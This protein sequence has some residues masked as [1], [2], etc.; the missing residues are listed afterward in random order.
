VIK[1]P[2]FPP[3]ELSAMKPRIIARIQSVDADWNSA[4]M[5]FFKHAYFGPRNSPYQ[6]IIP[7]T[8]Q[9]VSSFTAK[10]CA[11]WYHDKVLPARKVL[12]IYGDVS[13]D[14]ARQLA[15]KEFSGN[16]IASHAPAATKP[17]EAIPSLTKVAAPT[18]NVERI[19]VNKTELPVAGVIIGYDSD[20]VL[21]DPAN[22]P[23]TVGQTMAG[24]YG[25]PTGYLFEI[26]R[27]RGL[28]Y[29]VA[30]QNVPGR[31]AHLPGTFIVYAGC[32]PDKVNEVVNTALENI[33][34]LQGSAQAMQP[35]WFKRSK[36]LITTADALSREAPADQAMTAALDELFG[37]GYDYHDKFE[38]RINAVTLDQVRGIARHRLVHCVVTVSTPQPQLVNI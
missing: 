11:D 9:N 16:E 2:S 23:L 20:S 35:G 18:V 38:Q 8:K 24:G 30:D 14:A 31:N 36:E 21:G 1:N 17:S 10:D 12:A 5:K 19:A 15:E 4:S 34:R 22:F 32:D 29:V 28:V 25:Y 27:G 3:D 7:G 13:L 26:L 37:L 33:A 6:F